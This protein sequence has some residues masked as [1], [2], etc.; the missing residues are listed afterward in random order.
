MNLL[1]LNDYTSLRKEKK[2]IQKNLEVIITVGKAA[3]EPFIVLDLKHA[4]SLS[5]WRG[6]FTG[7]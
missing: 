5:K 7:E 2:S 1:W 4:Y 3:W 6:I